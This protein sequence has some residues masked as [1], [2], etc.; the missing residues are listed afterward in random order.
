MWIAWLVRWGLGEGWLKSF[1]DLAE[2]VVL[3]VL[4]LVFVVQIGYDLWKLLYGLW[5]EI[6]RVHSNQIVIS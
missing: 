1:I 2:K 5:K 6:L 3:A 4:F